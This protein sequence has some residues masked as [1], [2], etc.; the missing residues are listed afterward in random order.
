MLLSVFVC[1]CGPLL[2]LLGWP[3][4]DLSG[5]GICLPSR[6]LQLDPCFQTPISP[7][8]VPCPCCCSCV[9]VV[10][11]VVVAVMVVV[12]FC[13]CC[14]GCCCGG[15]CCRGCYVHW[16]CCR[17]Y[18]CCCWCCSP[19]GRGSPCGS[20]LLHITTCGSLVTPVLPMQM[21]YL[22]PR[23]DPWTPSWL[24]SHTSHTHLMQI[25]SGSVSRSQGGYPCH[26]GNCLRGFGGGQ[27]HR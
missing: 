15:C 25:L 3:L 6:P 23:T 26:S 16:C 8:C 13:C 7:I 1:L 12:L 11:V 17:C 2:L 14:C 27:H 4:S 21:A 19:S 9:V 18:C 10:D 20:D 22:E 24:A 5:E